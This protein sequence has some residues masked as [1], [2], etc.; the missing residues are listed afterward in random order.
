MLTAALAAV[1]LLNIALVL[2]VMLRPAITAGRSG[3]ILAFIALFLL[4]VVVGFSGIAEHTE[5]SKQTSFCL[6]CHIMESYG[7]SLHVDDRTYVPATH[8]QNNLVPRERAC[9][10]CH[11]DYTIYGGFNSK[12]RGLRHV[13]VQYLRPLPQ[14]VK[15]YTAYNN[16]ECLHCHAGARSFEEGA[17][18]SGTPG[19]LAAVRANTASCLQSGCHD[20]AHAVQTLKDAKYWSPPK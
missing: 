2:V 1:I 16:R 19:L 17:T 11:T 9:Y 8:F 3:K 12:L 6:S 15:L 5:R 20:T 18:H 13:Y 14:Q 4:P 10:T 7:R